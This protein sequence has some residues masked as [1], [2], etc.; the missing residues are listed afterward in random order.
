MLRALGTGPVLEEMKMS[1]GMDVSSLS[2]D[3]AAAQ[4]ARDGFVV[5]PGLFS[6]QEVL[7]W[8]GHAMARLRDLGK[9]GEP[10]GVHVWMHDT[11]DPDMRRWMADPRVLTVLER[12]IGPHI[13]FLSVK[14]VFKSRELTF[15]SPW[16]QDWFYWNGSTKVSVWI[17]L[18]DAAPDNGCLKLVP[19]SHTR[20][21]EMER[22]ED[23]KGFV[24]RIRDSDLR[25]LPVVSVPVARGGAVFFHDLA[26]HASHPNTRG[27]DRWS[28]ISTYRDA[29]VKDDSPVWKTAWVLRG[30]SVNG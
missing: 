16:H 30:R 10:S 11:L 6:E 21:F 25:G 28:L 4:Y 12:L 29:S 7:A 26:L 23:A 20:V 9:L 1:A 18:D 3:D 2:L 22:V 8:K 24:N 19:G 14:T 15:A 27:A 13:E 17:A 5:V